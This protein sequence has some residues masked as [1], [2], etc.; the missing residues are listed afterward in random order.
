MKRNLLALI[1]GAAVGITF[2]ALISSLIDNDTFVLSVDGDKLVSSL[3]RRFRSAT[4]REL[5][6]DNKISCDREGGIEL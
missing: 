2:G 1:S 5:Y 3:D 6:E 4:L